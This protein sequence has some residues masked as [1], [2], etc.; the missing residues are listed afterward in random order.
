M[1]KNELVLWLWKKT[2]G[3]PIVSE[4]TGPLSEILFKIKDLKKVS[5]KSIKKQIDELNSADFT[6]TQKDILLKAFEE[7]RPDL[8]REMFTEA[9]NRVM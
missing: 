6:Q 4:V 7:H 5:D 1:Q 3:S 8:Y 9:A 2:M